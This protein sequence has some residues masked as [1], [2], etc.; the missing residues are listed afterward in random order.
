MKASARWWLSGLKVGWCWPP[1]TLSGSFMSRS[2][3]SCGVF[4][5]GLLLFLHMCLACL[6]SLVEHSAP[7]SVICQVT[8]AKENNSMNHARSWHWIS[9]GLQSGVKP[10]DRRYSYSLGTWDMLLLNMKRIFWT[11]LGMHM[12]FCSIKS[13]ASWHCR[14]QRSYDGA[15]GCMTAQWLRC[16]CV[17]NVCD[18]GLNQVWVCEKA[19]FAPPTRM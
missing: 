11:G 17:F 10:K 19:V 1:M 16:W 14:T 9:Q 8:T 12:L 5:G 4:C 6:L 13:K 18:C 15:F 2:A 3:L 7:H